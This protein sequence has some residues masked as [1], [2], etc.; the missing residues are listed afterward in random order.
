[1]K[2]SASM[3]LLAMQMANGLQVS[4]SANKAIIS[5]DTKAAPAPAPT[6]AAKKRNSFQFFSPKKETTKTASETKAAKQPEA[7][8][9]KQQEASAAKPPVKEKVN[10]AAPEGGVAPAPAATPVSTDTTADTTAPTDIA[11]TDIAPTDIA[12]E[13]TSP[14]GEENSTDVKEFKWPTTFAHT[15]LKGQV[16]ITRSVE[17]QE[18]TYM[19]GA[20]V[21]EN[22]DDCVIAIP[23]K[24]LQGG[25]KRE[26][27]VV[28][29]PEGSSP[30]EGEGEGS[31]VQLAMEAM[32]GKQDEPILVEGNVVAGDSEPTDGNNSR[33]GSPLG[34]M[35]SDAVDS[36][37]EFGANLSKTVV[38]NVAGAYNDGKEKAAGVLHL[39]QEQTE[40]VAN[41]VADAEQKLEEKLADLTNWLR[42]EDMYAQVEKVSGTAEGM[43]TTQG[44]EVVSVLVETSQE[45]PTDV[46]EHDVKAE[47]IYKSQVDPEDYPEKNGQEA[48]LLVKVN[49]QLLSELFA[50]EDSG[51]KFHA[52]E[53]TWGA[54]ALAPVYSAG[55]SCYGLFCSWGGD[56]AP[57]EEEV[58]PTEDPA[59]EE[60]VTD[61]SAGA[62][63]VAEE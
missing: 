28:A 8:T 50:S 7:A 18:P 58:P 19:V 55:N 46:F 5:G 30:T 10:A 17:G 60:I 48:F 56:D 9:T 29:A 54:A 59:A 20:I 21:A 27:P 43:L 40:N 3:I 23:D 25:V 31:F 6:P 47:Q 14:P 42:E 36:V 38:D 26:A 41:R 34:D 22:D 13:T 62:Q 1:M 49:K 61:S 63:K 24:H 44:V 11:P 4:S 39:S 35:V 57:V 45:E 33:S 12:P 32:D 16:K 53:L 2:I 15:T 51:V 52:M 37:K